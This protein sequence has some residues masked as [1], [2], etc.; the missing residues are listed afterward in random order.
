ML[1]P[2]LTQRNADLTSSDEE[3]NLDDSSNSV[4]MT[5]NKAKEALAHFGTDTDGPDYREIA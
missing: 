3:I 5:P 4:T 2:T 1:Q